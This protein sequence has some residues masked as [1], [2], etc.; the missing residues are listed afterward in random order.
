MKV[1]LKTGELVRDIKRTNSVIEG[2]YRNIKTGE[3]KYYTTL[4]SAL[5]KRITK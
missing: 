2:F 4:P 1:K 5:W 3:I